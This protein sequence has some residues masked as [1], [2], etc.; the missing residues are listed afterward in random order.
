M[1]TVLLL[2]AYVGNVGYK[3]MILRMEYSMALCG[4]VCV[5]RT[6]IASVDHVTVF[7]QTKKTT[8]ARLEK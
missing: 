4:C 6:G 3:T 1:C 5:Y 8:M 7:P 2:V